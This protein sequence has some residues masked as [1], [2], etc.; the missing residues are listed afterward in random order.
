MTI[1][2]ARQTRQAS[3]VVNLL[4]RNDLTLQD[5]AVRLGY[6]GVPSFTKFVRRE[7]GV[8]PGVLR[9]QLRGH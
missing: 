5:V 2:E 4:Q 7:F 9:R 8:S 3:M 1:S 6:C